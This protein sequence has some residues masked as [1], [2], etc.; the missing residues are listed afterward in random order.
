MNDMTETPLPRTST[1]T[2]TT[3]WLRGALL[4]L[5]ERHSL[6]WLSILLLVILPLSLGDFRLGLAGKYLSLAFCAVGMEIH[7][8][9]VS[10]T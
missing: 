3:R 2:P 7:D 5:I 9:D 1:S 4:S 6:I 10:E 8:G